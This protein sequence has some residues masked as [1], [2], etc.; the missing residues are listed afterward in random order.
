[1]G[2]ANIVGFVLPPIIPAKKVI[3]HVDCRNRIH[4]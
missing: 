3:Y 1:M 2:H 4:F